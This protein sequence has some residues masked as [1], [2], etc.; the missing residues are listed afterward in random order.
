MLVLVPRWRSPVNR[1]CL[2]FKKESECPQGR[3][4]SNP[5][6]GVIIFIKRVFSKKLDKKVCNAVSSIPRNDRIEA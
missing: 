3:V 6:R 5:A 2:E 4:G 1:A